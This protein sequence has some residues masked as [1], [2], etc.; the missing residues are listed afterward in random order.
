[1]EGFAIG[2]AA[3]RLNSMLGFSMCGTPHGPMLSVR[4]RDS[5]MVG[6]PDTTDAVDSICRRYMDVE[7]KKA[8]GRRHYRQR[9]PLVVD[10]R[11]IKQEKQLPFVANTGRYVL[12]NVWYASICGLRGPM[13]SHI[14]H[15][16]RR[17]CGRLSEYQDPFGGLPR[18]PHG[19]QRLTVFLNGQNL[20]Q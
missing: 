17:L 1:M 10:C 8:R 13:R 5:C 3:G 15:G 6:L 11:Q 19:V 18:V 4:A 2:D 12:A 14:Q 9:K 7:Q 20:P 16:Q